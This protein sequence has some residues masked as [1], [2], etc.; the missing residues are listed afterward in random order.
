MFIIAIILLGIFFFSVV[1]GAFIFAQMF[2]RKKNDG[3]LNPVVI[4]NALEQMKQSKKGTD[5]EGVKMK[6]ASNL[7]DHL[8][9]KKIMIP[10]LEAKLRWFNTDSSKIEKINIC[11]TY[12][13][14]LAGYYVEAENPG[15]YIALIVH[16]YTDS[17]AGMAYLTEEYTKRG[18][19]V[20]AVDCR[21][22]GYSEG[23]VITLGYT[24]SKDVVLWVKEIV[25]RFNDKEIILHGVSMG[26]ATVVQALAQKKMQEFADR[27]KLVV[28]D[29]AFVSARSQLLNQAGSILGSTFIQ[30][31]ISQAVLCGMSLVNFFVCGFF[32]E[33]NSPKKAL[34]K[35]R[36][37][38]SAKVPLI[39]YHGERDSFVPFERVSV[40][41]AAAGNNA[42]AFIIKDAPH[43]GSY[44]YEPELYMKNIIEKLI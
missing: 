22:H 34:K 17:A 20:L 33:Q 19:S 1:A 36:K 40:L 5:L 29:C 15:K 3:S 2:V 38:A 16:G 21:S 9:D 25:K 37:L 41:E 4:A 39:F 35:R 43:I 26:G 13:K 32:M 31:M 27:I 44:F 14:K 6:G 10:L 30:K 12:G 11:G 8:N 28:S 7:A 23:K 18:I 42:K 24:D